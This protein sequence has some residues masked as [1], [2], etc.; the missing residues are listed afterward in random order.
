MLKNVLSLA[1]KSILYPVQGAAD[2]LQRDY[3]IRTVVEMAILVVVLSAIAAQAFSALVPLPEG[4]NGIIFA[5]SLH[6][7]FYLALFQGAV[8]I[9]LTGATFLVGRLVGGTGG[10][11]DTLILMVWLHFVMLLV[12]II[13]MVG[14]FALPMFGGILAAVSLALFFWLFI[15]FVTALHGFRS[16]FKVLVGTVVA[17]FLL[18]I[19]LVNLVIFV[20]PN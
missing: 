9:A 17:M 13:Q 15:N 11:K 8:L 6:F 19:G 1:R 14:T 18:G 12:Q 7:P 4:E 5:V 10:F 20:V 2:V 3:P 16:K